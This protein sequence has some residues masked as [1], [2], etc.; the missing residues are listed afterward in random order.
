[1]ATSP[2]LRPATQSDVEVIAPAAMTN[3][4][5][6]AQLIRTGIKTLLGEVFGSYLDRRELEAALLQGD[7]EAE[8]KRLDY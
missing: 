4:F 7:L 3:W 6:P 1:M 2:R 8:Q 5:S